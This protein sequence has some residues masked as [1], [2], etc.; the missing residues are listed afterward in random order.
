[1]KDFYVVAY[2]WGAENPTIETWGC[3]REN[4]VA[5][6]KDYCEDIQRTAV[7]NLPGAFVLSNVLS[8]NECKYFLEISESVGFVPDAAVSLPRSVRHNE[9]LTWVIDDSL[10]DIIWSRCQAFMQDEENIFNG[11][12]ALG[13]NKRFRFYKYAEGDYFSYHTDGAWPGSSIEN[14]KLITNAYGDRFSKMTFLLFLSDDFEG[15]ETSFLV[16]EKSKKFVDVRT[17]KGGVLCF[18]HGT[19]PLHCLHASKEI[20]AGVKYIIRSDILYE[21]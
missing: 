18:P 14:R 2:E 12:E 21:K 5:L 20:N 4:I 3:E 1:M 10:H 13:L 7:K 6:A 9:S 8:A 15:G 11:K 19:H 16:D 17:P